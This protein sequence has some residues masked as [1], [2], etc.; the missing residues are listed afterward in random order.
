M[1]SLPGTTTFAVII[2]VASGLSGYA[3]NLLP[4]E[5]STSFHPWGYRFTQGERLLYLETLDHLDSNGG[6]SYIS[7]RETAIEV[8]DVDST[9]NTLLE[10]EIISDSI[11]W[12]RQTTMPAG[13]R[14]DFI[15]PTGFRMRVRVTPLGEYIGGEIITDMKDRIEWRKS[16]TLGASDTVLMKILTGATLP[17]LPPRNAAHAGDRWGDTLVEHMTGAG[18]YTQSR[19]GNRSPSS[20]EEGIPRVRSSEYK[21]ER[22]YEY[23]LQ[24]NRLIDGSEVMVALRDERHTFSG[25]GEPNTTTVSTEFWFR[26]DDGV[27]VRERSVGT[28]APDAA[29]R[30]GTRS[31]RTRILLERKQT[32][33]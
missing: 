5:T 19:R 30:R 28:D 8:I 3:Q 17:S 11:V 22:I 16:G 9:G 33:R 1:S 26:A 7:T 23:M 12:R 18:I 24:G 6:D 15:D 25:F 31:V 29:N 27:L 4:A 14:S 21:I 13:Y 2:L 20:V 32:G 10:I